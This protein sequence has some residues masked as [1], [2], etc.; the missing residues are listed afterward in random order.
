MPKQALF[1][2]TCVLLAAGVLLAACDRSA[3][4][5]PIPAPGETPTATPVPTA[6][7]LP[8]LTPVPTPVPGGLA[9]DA[10][11]DLGPISPLIYG[12]NYGPW[13]VVPYDLLPEAEAAGIRFLRYPG[14]EWGDQNDL[15][16][17]QIDQFIAFAEQ[18]GA[19]PHI[20]VRLRG[21]TPE[22]SAELVRMANVEK[23]YGVRYWSIGNEPNIYPED[24]LMDTEEYN[25]AWRAHAEAMRAVDPGILFVGPNV[26]GYTGNPATD[27]RDDA[28]RDWM[29]EF[30]L[31]NGD[32]VDVVAIHYYPFP[33]SV[34]APPAT[35]DQLRANTP[36]WDALMVN[37]RALI[38][39]TT[40]RDL[41]IAIGEFNS[42]WN[43][44]V[45][46]EGTPD[47]FYNAI[48]LGDVLGRL[49][50]QKVE[51]AAF[52]MLR[53]GGGFGGFG[54]L[55]DREVYPTYYVYQIYQRFGSSLVY[56]SSD[57]PDVSIYAALRDD[58]ALTLVV[59]NLGSEA[60]EK[61]LMLEGF[62]PAGPAEVWL[63]DAEHQ[64][65]R[66][67]EQVVADG[68]SLALPAQSISLLILEP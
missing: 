8:T 61:R 56:S 33:S 62:E 19:E 34:N 23:G 52:F 43:H 35:I 10:A 40:G 26:T 2:W 46:G 47:S 36:R 48:W 67:G 59:I 58:G 21:G 30:L 64:A 7:P 18:I 20:C 4:Q 41:P 63:F 51:I 31:S 17:Y 27:P 49:I 45:G 25:A 22:A 53:A 37:L 14:G 28:G 3:D 11:L 42:H 12:A 32:L 16:A 24:D 13:A 15:R 57:D 1:S 29:R 50:R 55:G 66:V 65:E 44:A 39:E 38:R 60:Q 54:I 5:T 9:V 68:V 6:T